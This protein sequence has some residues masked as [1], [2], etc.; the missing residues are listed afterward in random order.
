MPDQDHASADASLHAVRVR[1]LVTL[2]LWAAALAL[3]FYFFNPLKILFLGILAAGCLA[4][5]L[6][7]ALRFIPAKRGIS[8]VVVGVA[9]ILLTVGLII[10]G[11][12]MLAAPIKREIQRWPQAQQRLDATL[13]KWSEQWGLAEPLTIE[14]LARQSG[15]A[16]A[17]GPQV[18]KTGTGVLA[19]V[20][21]ALAFV[22]FGSIYM[23]A[24]PPMRIVEPPLRAL[25]KDRQAQIKAALLDLGPGLRWW[26]I[27]TL[28][29]M[30]V[31]AVASWGGFALV[32]LEFAVPLALLAGL[33]E[34]VPTVGPAAAFLVALLFAATQ[35]TGTVIGVGLVYIIV[36]IGES[37]LL[38]PMVMK[39]AVKMPPLVTLFTVVLWGK[40]LG[41]A[42][43]FLALP[44]N[45]TLW[46][47]FKHLVLESKPR[48]IAAAA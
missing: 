23:L 36:Q 15:Q 46:S 17:S 38:L 26:V 10:F 19:G 6:H 21:L 48:R 39:K 18:I 11:S 3:F 35:G 9:P 44:I 45:L 22:F 42:G 28:I 13:A 25:P 41:P 40:L 37:Y 20:A 33:A 4:A 1:H 27:G 8:A 43:L 34:M 7:P 30:S 16:F 5:A 47:F 12:W 14:S 2:F 31:V 24:E 32:G 29:S